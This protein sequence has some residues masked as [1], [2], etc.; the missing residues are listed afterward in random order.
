M[1]EVVVTWL[2]QNERFI[3]PDWIK[4]V[5]SRG[6]ER[7]R[8][9][10]TKE[11]ER[12]FFT[13]FYHAF[14]LAVEESSRDPLAEVLER[15]AVTRVEQEFQLEETLDIFFLLKELIW[16][17]LSQSYSADA[18]LTRICLIEPTFNSCFRVLSRAFTRASRKLLSERLVEAEFMTRRLAIAT[19]EADRALSRLRILYNVSRAISSMLDLKQIL[20]AV[21]E[22]LTS[23][24][25]I[26][27]SAVW[28]ADK[29]AKELS[30]AVARGIDS[31][32]LE[33]VYLLVDEDH[34]IVARA[35]QTRQLQLVNQVRIE[36]EVLAPLFPQRSLLA[37]PLQGEDRPLG[38]ISVD[39][40]A[41]DRPFE[42]A[43]IE[44][45][46]SIADQAGV[47]LHNTQLYEELVQL[48]QHL[49][50]RVQERTEE[51][52]RLNR[53]LAKLDKKKSDFIAIAAHELKTPLTLI[54]GYAEM[55]AEGGIER[56]PPELLERQMSGIVKGAD[57]L[58]MIVEDIIDVSLIDTQVLAL[59]LEL[60]SLFH[61]VEL[62]CRDQ[63]EA[64]KERK[65][66][67]RLGDFS[68]LPN[69][70][71]DAL[72]LHQMFGNIV[73][74]AIKYTPDGGTVG[75]AARLLEAEHEQP[76][77]VEVVVSDTGVGIDLEEQE[78][79][80]DKF[81]RVESPDLHSS[82][83]T[84]F[85]GAG[86]GLGLAIAKGIVEAHG[87]RIWVESP[88]YDP[89]RCPGSQFHVL[90]PVRSAWGDFQ[91]REPLGDASSLHSSE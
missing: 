12:Q 86:P 31:K 62:A 50:Q 2:R 16:E 45:V 59:N 73:G 36:E 88:G 14:V 63:V 20:A 33:G 71:A 90:L 70:E 56:M 46:Q 29:E 82:S 10:T 51:L 24:S 30:V 34:S 43:V 74:N 44:M 41:H 91:E 77:F 5:R 84:R 89:V 80:F 49:D 60:T 19:E 58:R 67:V 42:T 61:V 37:V 26:D 69:I 9:L 72:R 53:E 38:V 25:Q 7:D 40:L 22:N 8:Q 21:A 11:L 47:A 27:R 66:D 18:A 1:R 3:A 4:M 48:N 15:I 28:L 75:I 39:R 68:D 78:R 76:A 85:M 65:L 52:A 13:D 83:K 55:L 32:K 23:V 79:I 17:R 64:A 35:F 57:R 54:Q 6:G 87:G 81:Y